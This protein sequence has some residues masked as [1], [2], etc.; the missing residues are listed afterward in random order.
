MGIQK[1]EFYEGAA[2]HRLIR[3]CAEP[4]RVLH[5]PP[6]FILNSL[7]A[8]HFKYSTSK[9]T[10]WGF[11]LLPAEQGRLKDAAE[12]LSVVIAFVCG[13][14]GIAALPYKD[15]LRVVASSEAASSLVC[16]RLYKEHYE[17]SGPGG[18]LERK[19]APSNWCSILN[20]EK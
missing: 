9:R 20:K 13:S 15:Y 1:Q 4:V 14:D 3:A 12:T 18:T 16:R 19:V 5:A 7:L 6:F 10:P 2:L 8:V 11:T 17:I